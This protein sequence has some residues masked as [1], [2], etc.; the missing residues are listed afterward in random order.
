MID[1]LRQALKVDNLELSKAGKL[2][3]STDSV[4]VKLMLLGKARN[5]T[6]VPKA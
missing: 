6:V 2:I 5:E 1:R 3:L 4:P